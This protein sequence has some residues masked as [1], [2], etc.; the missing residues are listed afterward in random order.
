VAGLW[1]YFS[2][3]HQAHA[4]AQELHSAEG[5]YWHGILHRQE[6]DAWNA[7]YWFQRVKK[8]PIHAP[9]AEEAAAL[10]DRHDRLW[11]TPG[12]WDAA[13]FVEFCEAARRKPGGREE[14][15]A[16]E[17]QRVEWQ[18]LFDWCAGREAA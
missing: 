10:C 18:L 16:L 14:R 6:P 7:Q 8:H 4:V 5:S 12:V 11:A 17:I 1:V 15:L 2:A 13:R 9:L 3:F